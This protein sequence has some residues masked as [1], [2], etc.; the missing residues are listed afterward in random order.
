M[1]QSKSLKLIQLILSIY[2]ILILV[3][4]IRGREYIQDESIIFTNTD[5][6][7]RGKL[8]YIDYSAVYPLGLYFYLSPI[9]LFFHQDVL[10]VRI[11]SWT[12][13]STV[14]F[15]AINKSKSLVSVFLGALMVTYWT[16]MALVWNFAL[17]IFLIGLLAKNS[18]S[19]N[20]NF[21]GTFLIGVAVAIRPDFGLA[22]L[23]PTLIFILKKKSIKYA[24]KNTLI[25]L[26]GCAP[27]VINFLLLIFNNQFFSWLHLQSEIRKGRFLNLNTY[28]EPTTYI[29]LG[30]TIALACILIVSWSI[31]FEQ[32]LPL[33]NV[34]F[35]VPGL[36]A[37][38]IFQLVQRA[39]GWHVRYLIQILI[40]ILLVLVP[41]NY[42][43]EFKKLTSWI[44]I[45]VTFLILFIAKFEVDSNIRDSIF[46]WKIK[47]TSIEYCSAK[48][49][50]Y[51]S[52]GQSALYS[53]ILEVLER[54]TESVRPIFIGPSD[55]RYATY[56]DTW[57]YSVAQNPPCT[58]YTEMNP[59]DSNSLE[60]SLSEDILKCHFL[61]LNDLYNEKF[62]D[63]DWPGQAGPNQINKVVAENFIEI[64]NSNG[65]RLLDNVNL[66]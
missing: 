34:I 47:S 26:I 14:I 30:L 7:L 22:V 35:Y 53:P 13:I 38:G 43:I 16:Q 6:F 32:K 50:V 10:F 20:I 39:D 57:I 51:L 61:I 56:G 37:L 21:F 36:L 2:I 12:L 64:Y 49:C 28:F 29:I 46:P 48:R 41:L 5:F 4:T 18:K 23:V 31:P 42:K 17:S 27:T 40:G 58:R 59:G 24:M 60:S 52:P 8:P 1:Q 19:I 15:L 11:L 55:L 65:F 9:I 66:D 54:P 44:L 33:N 63:N 62:V 45:F 25:F 3:F